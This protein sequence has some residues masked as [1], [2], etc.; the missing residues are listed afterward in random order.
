MAVSSLV[1]LSVIGRDYYGVFPLKGK[2]LNVREASQKQVMDN[3]EI[4]SIVEIMGL[5]YGKKYDEASLAKLRYGYCAGLLSS[6]SLLHGVTAA[7]YCAIFNWGV[8]F[9]GAP[10]G[11]S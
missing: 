4:K 10:V 1:G 9:D 3:Q 5:Q 7:V 6:L 8:L 11:L 2:P